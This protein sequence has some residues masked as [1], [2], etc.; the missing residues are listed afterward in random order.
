MPRAFQ[1]LRTR[2]EAQSWGPALLE[3]LS[4]GQLMESGGGAAGGVAG[5]AGLAVV[6]TFGALATF[7][8]IVVLGVFLAADPGTYRAG[9][10]ALV[11]PSGRERAEAVLRQLGRTL[12]GWLLAQI[13]SMA[14][15]GAL[16][17]LGLWL[18]G[19]Q[20]AVVLGVILFQALAGFVPEATR[21]LREA[22]SFVRGRLD[23]VGPDAVLGSSA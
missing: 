4:P 21:S 13:S 6:S 15:I 19:V 17:A 23:P 22:A 11:A 20:L 9:V 2:L 1:G 16:T 5:R 10:V 7:A 8:I 3:R 12:Q 18:L 14:V